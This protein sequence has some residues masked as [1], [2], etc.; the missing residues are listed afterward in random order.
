MNFIRNSRPDTR[1]VRWTGFTLT[2]LMIV[3]VIIGLLASIAIP[4]VVK[5]RD[6]TRLNVTYHYLR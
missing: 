2:E 6:N 5:A 3:I 4:V 1:I